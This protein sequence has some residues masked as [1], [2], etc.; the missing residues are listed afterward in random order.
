MLGFKGIRV[1]SPDAVGPAW[2]DAFASDRPVLLEAVVDPNV[3]P[4]PPHIE[5]NQAKKLMKSIMAGDPD[6]RDVIKQGFKGK[7]EEF[8]HR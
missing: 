1:D 5:W 3:P 7:I 4:L 8:L 2:D 6:A